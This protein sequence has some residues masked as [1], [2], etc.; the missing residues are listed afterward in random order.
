MQRTHLGQGREAQEEAK[1]KS[2]NGEHLPEQGLVADV[3]ALLPA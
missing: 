3:V 1:Q 2:I